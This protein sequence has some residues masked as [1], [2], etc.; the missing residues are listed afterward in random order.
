MKVI[1]YPI[2]SNDSGPSVKDLQNALLSIAME[3][4]HTKFG[5]LWKEPKFLKK[6]SIEYSSSLYGEATQRAVKVFQRKLMG[7]EPTGIVD[8][9]TAA[10]LERDMH[11]SNM[12]KDPQPTDTPLTVSGIVY[13]QWIEPMADAVV[14]IFDQDIRSEHRLGEGVTDHEGKYSISYSKDRL[15]RQDKGGA[16]LIVKLYGEDGNVLYTSPVNFNAADQLVVNVNLGARAYL[17]L[18]DFVKNVE[19]VRGF[20]GHLEIRDLTESTKVHDLSFLISKTGISA[21]TLLLLVAAFR[22]EKWTGLDAEV[23]YGILVVNKAIATT[24]NQLPADVDTTIEQAYINFWTASVTSDL[25]ALQNAATNNTITY[26]ILKRKEEIQTALQKLIVAPPQEA[27]STQTLP[28]V[29]TNLQTAGLSTAQ[30]QAFLNLYAANSINTSFW[31]TLA[32]DP[33]FQGAAGTATINKLQTIYQIAGWTANNTALTAYI[34]KTYSLN[35]PGDF[36]SLVSN[37]VSN[38]TTIITASGTL[39]ANTTAAAINTLAV[40]I[41]AGIEQLYP[42]PV[43]ADRFSK[44]TTLTIPNQDYITGVL[45]STDFD[46]Q[47]STITTYM[48][49]YVKNN[50]IPAGA[51]VQAITYHV[52]GLQRTY[53]V[54]QSADTSITL[55]AGNIQSA[56]QIYAMGKSNFVTQYGQTLGSD[57]AGLVYERAAQV[58]AAAT[59][60]LGNLV[61][62]VGNAQTNILPNYNSQLPGSNLMASYPDLANLFGMAAS[63]CECA[64]C[65]SFLGI[66]AYLTDLLDFLHQRNTPHTGGTSTNARATLLANNYN[67]PFGTTDTT[68]RRRPDIGDI[69]LNCDNTNVELPYIDI[70]NELLEDYII[71]PL[72]M[73]AL[74]IQNSEPGEILSFFWQWINTYL[75]PGTINP[76]IFNL[77]MQ[78]GNDPKTPICNIDLLTSN[79]VVSEIFITDAENYPSWMVPWVIQWV[80]RDQYITLKVVL[81]IETNSLQTLQTIFGTVIQCTLAPGQG[82]FPT[83]GLVYEVLE[84]IFVQDFSER[85][86]GQRW[87]GFMVQEIH[88]T[89]LTTDEINANPEYTNTN[90]YN[91]LRDPLQESTNLWNLYPATGG[92]IPLSLPFDLYFDEANTYLQKM[93]IQRANLMNTFSE[94][95]GTSLDSIVIAYMGLSTGDSDIIFTPRILDGAANDLQIQFWGP[96]IISGSNLNDLNVNVALFLTASGLT[97]EQLVTLLTLTFINPSTPGP[98][99][100]I[101]E[102]SG[103][104]PCNT[105][106]MTISNMTLAKFDATNRFLRLW[107]KLNGVTTISMHEL[108][109]CIMCPSI[110]NGTLDMPFAEKMYYFLQLMSTLSLTATQTLVFYQD[111]DCS[112]NTYDPTFTSLY[113]QLFQNRQIS[114]PLVTAFTLPTNPATL[115]I[116]TISYPSVIPVILTACGITQAD[117]TAILGIANPPITTLT[118]DTLSVIYAYGLLSNALSIPVADVLTFITLSGFHPVN[119]LN[120]VTQA[121]LIQYTPVDTFTFIAK[122]NE[123]QQAGFTVDELNY[124]L[125]NQSNAS[126]SLIPNSTAVVSGLQT[127]RTAIQA[128]ITATTAAPDPQGVLLKKWL[129]DPDLNWDPTIA[130]KLVSILS[131]AGSA[132]YGPQVQNNLRFLQLLQPAY[133]IPL[134]TAALEQLPPIQFPDTTITGILYDDTNYYLFY[135]GTMSAELWKLPIVPQD[136]ATQAIFNALY[137]QSQQC[138]ISAVLLPGAV[139]AAPPAWVGQLGLTDPAFSGGAGVLGFPGKMTAAVYT[140]LLAQSNDPTYGCALSQLFIASQT[141]ASGVSTFV[142]LATLPAIQLPAPAA[143]TLTYHSTTLSYSGIMTAADA[144][145][146]LGLSQPTDTAFRA[147]VC[148]LFTSSIAGQTVSAPLTTP[149]AGWS[150]FQDITGIGDLSYVAGAVPALCYNGQMNALVET[151]LESLSPNSGWLANIQALFQNTQSTGITVLPV[152][153]PSGTLFPPAG[154]TFPL[155]NVTYAAAA[156][157]NPATLSYT[158]PMSDY[159]LELLLAASTDPFWATTVTTLYQNTQANLVTAV[160]FTL[161]ASLTLAALTAGIAAIASSGVTITTAASGQTILSVTGQ[162]TPT[163]QQQLL[164]INT[165]P[166]YTAAIGYL[167]TQTSAILQYALPLIGIPLPDANIATTTYD[168]NGAILFTG[169]PNV[170]CMDEFNLQQLS[171]DPDYIAA[172]GWIY[173]TPPATPIPSGSVG[174]VLPALP[175]ITLPTTIAITWSEGQLF[176]LGQMQTSDLTTLQALSADPFYTAALNALFAASQITFVTSLTSLPGSLTPAILQQ[177]SPQINCSQVTTGFALTCTGMMPAA[178]QT[179]LLGLNSDAT[180]QAAINSLYTQSNQA[181]NALIQTAIPLAALPPITIPAALASYDPINGVLYYSGPLPMPA[182]TNTALESICTDAGYQGALQK[183]SQ[184]SIVPGT[185]S[186]MVFAPPPQTPFAT[187]GLSLYNGAVIAYQG[188]TIGFTGVMSFADYLGL[189]ALSDD[190]DY[191]SVVNYMFA[192]GSATSS[193]YLTLPPITIPAIYTNQ[194]SFSAATDTLTLRGYLAA[195]DQSALNSL[196]SDPAYN[197]AI[198]TVYAAVNPPNQPAPEFFPNPYPTLQNGAPAAGNLYTFYLTAISAIYQPIKV[199]EA[200]EAQIAGNFGISTAIA[201]VLVNDLANASGTLAAAMA[202]PVFAGNSNAINPDPNQSPQALWYMILARIAF[203]ITNFNLS[204]DDT[205]WLLKNATS[206]NLLDPTKNALDLSAYP[207]PGNPLLFS[208]WEVLNDVAVFQRQYHPITIPDVAAPGQNTTLSV[209]TILSAA[210]AIQSDITGG[211]LT[212]ISNPGA[213]LAQLQLLTGWKLTELTYLLNIGQPSPPNLIPNPLNLTDTGIPAIHSITDLSDISI[214]LRLSACFTMAAQLKVVPSRCATWVVDPLT[215]NTAL[216]IKQALK[217]MY[218]DDTSWVSAIQP[219]MNTLRQNRRDALLAYLLSNPVTNPF[220]YPGSFTVFPDEYH[221]YGNFLI[222]IEMSSCQPTTRVIQAYCSVQL[223]VQR[224]IMNIEAPA[225]VADSN[226][227]TD[228]LYWSWMGTFETWYEARYT[229]LYPENFILPQ[230]LPNQSAFFVDMQNDL[231]QGP[232]TTAIVETAYG[233]YLQSLDEVARLEIKGMW[234]DDPTDTLHV[235][236]RTYGG[237]PTSYFYRT[238]NPLGV[239]SPWASVTADISGDEIIPVVQNGRV[240]LYWPVFTMASDDDKKPVQNKTLSQVKSSKPTTSPIPVKY[241]TIQMAFSE[242]LNGQWTGKKISTDSVVS[243]DIKYTGSSQNIASPNTTDFVF[244]AFDIPPAPN[245]SAS[246][247]D[248]F[249]A[250]QQSLT[251]NNCMIIACYYWTGGGLSTLSGTTAFQLDPLK[252]YPSTSLSSLASDF[253]KA[254]GGTTIQ[255]INMFNTATFY[256]MLV[257]GTTPI[258]PILDG[259]GFFQLLSAKNISYTSLLSMQMGLFAKY[260]YQYVIGIGDSAQTFYEILGNMMPFFYQDSAKTFFVKQSISQILSAVPMYPPNFYY[261]DAKNAFIATKGDGGQLNNLWNAL[262]TCA[263]D[264][265]PGY[266]FENYYHPFV[267]QFIKIFAQPLLGIE[268]VLTRQIQLTGDPNKPTTAGAKPY[269]QLPEVLSNLIN[270]NSY[271]PFDFNKTYKPTANVLNGVSTD[272]GYPVD[273][274]D[275]GPGFIGQLSSYGQYNWELFF[276]SVLLSAMQLSQNQQFEDADTWFKFIFNPTDTTSNQSPQKFWVTKPFFENTDASLTIDELILIADLDPAYGVLFGEMVDLWRSDPYDAHLLA[277]LRITPYMYTTFMKYLDNL[278]AWAN[279]NYQ[280]YTMETVNIA[281]QLFMTALESLGTQPE[282]IPPIDGAAVC[283]YYQLELGLDA[284]IGYLS[285]PLV[286]LENLLP[287]PS[288]NPSSPGGSQKLQMLAGL[289]FC[290]PPNPVLLAYWNTIETQLTKIRNCENIAGQFQPLSPFPSVGGAGNMDGSG[291][292]DFGGVLPNYRFSVMIQKANE[293][294]NEVKSL[295]AALLSALEKQD[296]EGLALLRSS[297]EIAVQQSIDLVKQKQITDAQLALQNLQNYQSL[298]NDKVTYYTDLLQDGGLISLETQAL[299]LVQQALSLEDNVQT[300]TEVASALNIIPS[301]SFGINGCGGTPKVSVSFGGSNLGAAATCFTDLFSSHQHERDRNAS[302]NTTLAGYARRSAEWNFQLTLAQDELTQTATQIQAAQ[303]KIAI[304]TQEEQNQQLLIS[305]AQDINTFLNN[306]YTNQQLYSWMV[307]QI[308]NVYFQSYQLA[309]SF[310]K[311]AEICFG[312]EL[313]I[314]GSSYIN[315]GYWDSLHKGLLSGEGLMSNLKQMET[316]YYNLNIREY[317]ITRQ[318]SL[319]QLDASALLQLKANRTCFINIPEELFDMD[320]PGQYFRRIKHIAVTIPG[321]VGPYTPVCLKMT[322]MSNSVRI[323]STAGTANTYPRNTDSTGA[324]TND[325]RFLDNYSA[326]QYIATSNGVNDNG[327]FEMNLRDERYLPFE[328]GGAISTWQLEFPSAY[329][330]FDPSTITDLILHFSYTSRDGGVGLQTV[331]TQSVQSK[332]KSAM[333]APGLVLM[334]GFSARRDFPTQWYK[335]LNPPVVTDPQE[336]V[337]DITSRF[338][339]FTQ[340]LKVVVSK[341]VVVA[342]N[343]ASLPAMYISGVKLKNGLIDFGLDPDYGSMSYGEV[344]CKDGVGVWTISNGPTTSPGTQH[345]G[346]TDI[347]DLYVFFYYSLINPAP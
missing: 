233:N 251:M 218:P 100:W 245:H 133:T 300:S 21:S 235:F 246:T 215:N 83:I 71:P 66:P 45:K 113:Q 307:T 267:H 20:I 186:Y 295:G 114:N 67:L 319:A 54:T 129:A 337:M 155:Y 222:D 243:P 106:Q 241:W 47:K 126:P 102:N 30:Q 124:I 223:F 196:S 226:L 8:K 35:T 310:A 152:T 31:T 321:V 38:W 125:C 204:A 343:N 305:N 238:L 202:N 212:A 308:S 216:D 91:S 18:S 273:Q 88:Q 335:F 34:A 90:V 40:A 48:A 317:E 112:T 76:A 320:Y 1:S 272:S 253:I 197:L 219:I 192:F 33:S 87:F 328:R 11:K 77:L 332:L 93:G 248:Q 132:T 37:D 262:D 170:N 299:S 107:N 290:I 24:N 214:L 298:L 46:I 184:A 148:D 266:E 289:Y 316:A 259:D 208:N 230:T 258:T 156:G 57:S 331:A 239:W 58:H 274:M 279:Y 210:L 342:D 115:S 89:H 213:L 181:S 25:T 227:D 261:L 277:Q 141:A 3:W 311:Q 185:W 26:S 135:Y 23:Y 98:Q 315:Y 327:L 78:I 154:V 314:V 207:L 111:I 92:I 326:I 94:Q 194:V 36:S 179:T 43:F 265:G 139:P 72:A 153:P 15:T 269:G 85:K 191:V 257:T 221:V 79:A 41:A 198:N 131:A 128:A 333:T 86:E 160:Q 284:N 339:F 39:P 231:A 167:F 63:Y 2:E 220:S 172:I 189:L 13:D 119:P 81:T 22:F 95:G 206:I 283:N 193:S 158:G 140:A 187:D 280:Q 70:V 147:A 80:I 340:G 127:I 4:D 281:I 122:F 303:N 236:A 182:A 180:Y 229:F 336:L 263:A 176:F 44:S 312:Y 110:G 5:K 292:A 234:Y 19:L 159:I 61:A 329:P 278:I 27:G 10:A 195:A 42:T 17:G 264:S 294:C 338:P 293:L 250:F 254:R 282:S 104:D 171:T 309:Y 288:P 224:C 325:S 120:P 217:S 146:I 225:I 168:A 162:L 344:S 255:N 165:D 144:C 49:S 345:I 232:V 304:A 105:A 178:L 123:V 249:T 32:Q 60:T 296:A 237:S 121:R 96:Q 242:Y 209:Y 52:M 103:I 99:S 240:Y 306:K 201:V 55:L 62:K 16:N 244:V 116:N 150:A 29:Y 341:V 324:P 97:F 50:P 205:Y 118:L 313:G 175:A 75:A 270:T 199:A 149:P 157:S 286:Q 143:A 136:A 200:L 137:T 347:N 287:P 169:T 7:I 12:N 82:K 334:R 297:Q 322:L 252:G 151:A 302:I 161:P 260:C 285:D 211:A 69:D 276:H 247:A 145:V 228:W 130:A 65:E 134:A 346:N 174:A 142:Q 28:P 53:K 74:E 275:F 138:A 177:Q 73:I 9:A 6:W 14:M 271:T 188:G 318:I 256:N 330:L 268:Q 173:Q 68:W 166:V 108:D 301:F 109:M 64:D 323:D 163:I 84:T 203:L 59:H 190:P 117:L 291:V 51:D 101:V 56:R 183:L 164:A